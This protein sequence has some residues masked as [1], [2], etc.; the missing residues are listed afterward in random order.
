MNTLVDTF[1]G[2]LCRHSSSRALSFAGNDLG[3]PGVD[4][5]LHEKERKSARFG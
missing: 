2:R 1:L 5:G 4:K 3:L